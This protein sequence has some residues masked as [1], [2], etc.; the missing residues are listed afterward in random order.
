[1]IK[2]N[3]CQSK[4]VTKINKPIGTAMVA[5]GR[6]RKATGRLGRESVRGNKKGQ[7]KRRTKAKKNAVNFAKT[8]PAALKEIAKFAAAAK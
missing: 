1:M 8:V 5:E 7:V 2:L 4:G 6:A 3:S